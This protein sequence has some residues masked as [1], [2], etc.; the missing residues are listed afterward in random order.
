M[1]SIIEIP[2]IKLIYNIESNFYYNNNGNK[3]LI[4]ATINPYKFNDDDDDFDDDFY[5]DFDGD[6]YDNCDKYSKNP[7]K[8]D[9]DHQS[10]P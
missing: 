2:T 7:N 5:D 3:N 1:S 9:I 8:D 10:N 6:D 4:N